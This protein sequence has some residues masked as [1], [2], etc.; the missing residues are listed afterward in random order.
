MEDETAV[1]DVIGVFVRLDGGG[2]GEEEVNMV[3]VEED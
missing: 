3:M 2:G 1:E